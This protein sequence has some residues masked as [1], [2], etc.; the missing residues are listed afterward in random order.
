M[1]IS[2]TAA[3]AIPSATAAVFALLYLRGRITHRELQERLRS[4]QKTLEQKRLELQEQKRR[5]G[6]KDEF[7][8]TVS[9]ELR[10]PLTSIRGALGLLSAGVMGKLDTKASNLLRI[11]SSNTDRLTRLINDVLDLER[12]DSGSAPMQLRPCS[13]RELIEQAVETMT[14]MAVDSGVKIEVVPE[15]GGMPAA[16][17][18]DPDRILQV[19]V[20]LLSNAIKFSPQKSTILITSE[21]DAEHLGFNVKDAG[22]GVPAEKLESI[23][24]RFNQV[25]TSDA[26]QKG[27]TGLGLAICRTILTQHHGVI[28]AHRN[29]ED[30]TG[31]SGTTFRVRLPRTP[32][33]EAAFSVQSK[34][35]AGAILVCDDDQELRSLVAEQ[36][37]SHGYKALEIRSGEEALEI[38][39]REPV[40]AILLDL[41]PQ[42]STNWETMELLK[43]DERTANIPLVALSILAQEQAPATTTAELAERAM[44]P[45][46]ERHLL[47]QLVRI[48]QPGAEQFRVLL[49]EDDADLAEVVLSSFEVDREA[50]STHVYHVH[51][52][53]EAQSACR[54][55]PP[56]MIILDLKLPDGS[57]F[58]LVD[59]LR[60]QPSL[61]A[62]PLIV[63]S[64]Q[65]VTLRDKAQLRLGPT[66]FL[67]KARVSPQEVEQLVLAMLRQHQIAAA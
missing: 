10:T 63:Y 29:D 5:D 46:A 28:E 34:N 11:A 18:G 41:A 38:A 35:P 47:A 6:I 15:P 36:L 9:H 67:D 2:H 60:S 65:D 40:E 4:I 1:T 8:S 48:L 20:N 51:S 54:T 24:E 58:A 52:M 55:L 7:I 49:V 26:R 44:Q 31:L 30:G 14:P 13:L 19:L 27:G 61:R 56:Q 62:L 53:A 25:E 12:M 33:V 50:A 16:F 17:E 39:A 45:A 22:R 3:I 21:F 23:F 57:G 32:S 42:G 37:R 66:E 43:K 64:G 59:W